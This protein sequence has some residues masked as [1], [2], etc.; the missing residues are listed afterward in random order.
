M[1]TNQRR[2]A[3][4]L[5]FTVIFGSLLILIGIAD[6]YARIYN[7][8][9][10]GNGDGFNPIISPG[11]YSPPSNLP[12]L[13][14]PNAYIALARQAAT[15]GK[16]DDAKQYASNAL[17]ANPASGEAALALFDFYTRPDLYRIEPPPPVVEYE[18]DTEPVLEQP[19][20][21]PPEPAFVTLSPEDKRIADK[22]ADINQVMRPSYPTTEDS[23]TK[24][25]LH[26]GRPDKALPGWHVMLS[27][28]PALSKEIFP[29][30]LSNLHD[31]RLQ[32]ALKPYLSDPPPWWDSFLKYQLEQTKP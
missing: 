31:S 1:T 9:D 28:Y 8:P 22:L 19:A 12:F 2:R 29:A 16:M 17:K 5:T 26:Q 10:E 21:P 3:L 23:V 14:P 6:N 7:N 4:T 30:L 15:D 13:F 25:W 20:P 32:A 27:E 24:Y 11:N 18:A